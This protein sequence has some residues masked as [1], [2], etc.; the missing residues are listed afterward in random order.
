MLLFVLAR[1]LL[2]RDA[3]AAAAVVVLLLAPGAAAG[4]ESAWFTL[5]VMAVWQV[6][7]ILLLLRFGLLAAIVGLFAHD[8]L[9]KGPLVRGMVLTLEPGTYLKG[10]LGVRIEDTY[11]VTATGCEAL[12]LGLP[13]DPASIEEAMKGPAAPARGPATPAN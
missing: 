11:E 10:E 2:R 5:P 12:T 3:L 13:A 7:W 1:L 8:P 9:P 4:G 6:S